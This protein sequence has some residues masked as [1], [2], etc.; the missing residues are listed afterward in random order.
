MLFSDEFGRGLELEI[1][2]EEWK[3]VRSLIRFRIGLARKGKIILLFLGR[4]R[5]EVV[6]G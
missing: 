3:N 4:E 6:M 1:M 2:M 5:K